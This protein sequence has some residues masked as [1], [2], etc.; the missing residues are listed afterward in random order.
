MTESRIAVTDRLRQEGRWEEAC[1]YRD[2]IRKQLRA[3]GMARADANDRAWEAMVEKF[4]PLPPVERKD[5][6]DDWWPEDTV[7][8]NGINRPNLVRDTLWVYEHLAQR[9]VQP[10]DAPSAGAWALLRWARE[11][12][13]RFFEQLLPKAMSANVQPD[14]KG[15]KYDAFY[16]TTR[17]SDGM[18][19][20]D[21]L[22]QWGLKSNQ[23]RG[24]SWGVN[25]DDPP[26]PTPA[27]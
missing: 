3:D 14:R 19:R 20:L 18:A 26:L 23:E 9:N 17:K 16:D 4:P 6:P 11:Y 10:Q 25:D 27:E 5:D 7:T 22:L 1:L 15:E 21:A 2:N 24:L 13:N 8:R 12:R